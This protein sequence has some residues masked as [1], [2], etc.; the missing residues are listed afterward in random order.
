MPL[1]QTTTGLTIQDIAE[2]KGE[3]EESY[4]LLFGADV[5]LGVDSVFGKQIGVQSE[6][7]ALLQAQMQFIQAGFSRATAQATNLDAVARLTGSDR[8]GATQSISTAGRCTGTDTTIILN[9]SSVIQQNAGLDSWTV[10]NGTDGVGPFGYEIGTVVSGEVTGVEIEA[11]DTGPKVFSSS[12]EFVIGSPIAG[13]DNFNPSRDIE[14]YETGQD[15]EPDGAFR[16]R[17][18]DELFAGGNDTSG[19]K[20]VITEVPGVSEVQVFE[21]RDCTTTDGDGIEPGHVESIVTGG[22][23]LDVATAILLRVPPGTSLQGTTEVVLADTEGNQIPIRFTRPAAVE[24]YVNVIIINFSAEGT[25]PENFQDLAEAA[26]LEFGNANARVSQDV[27][28][29]QFIGP[30]A[31]SIQDTFTGKFAYNFIDSEVG[32]TSSTSNANIPIGIRERADYDSSRITVVL[33]T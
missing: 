15:V 5:S 13:W 14:T 26:V 8:R 9:G 21:N 6:R 4:R 25:L 31:A 22:S 10:V 32:L 27:L 7:E 18:R 1:A 28:Y 29:Q 11:V 23:D 24:I 17:S 20:A 19:I 33:D 2:I 12:S 30:V 3:Y 16:D